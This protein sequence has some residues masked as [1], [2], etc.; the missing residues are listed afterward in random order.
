MLM[1]KKFAVLWGFSMAVGLYTTFVLMVLWGWFVVPAF[2][3]EAISFWV[4][5]G[6]TLLIGLFRTSGDFE[7][8]HR[9][10]IIATMIDACVPADNREE[11]REQLNEFNEEIW[12][13]AGLKVAGRVL[14]NTLALGLGFLV[15]IL[16]S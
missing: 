5:Y 9:H 3:V 2:H 13:D 12:R 7:G 15:H 14:E 6:F 8:E 11:L 1:I 10:K 4:M 16:A